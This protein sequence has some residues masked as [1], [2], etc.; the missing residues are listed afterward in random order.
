MIVGFG[1][2][3]GYTVQYVGN[4]CFHPSLFAPCVFPIYRYNLQ[5]AKQRTSNLLFTTPHV[6]I[7]AI[8]AVAPIAASAPAGLR[9]VS[10]SVLCRR[11]PR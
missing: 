8:V 2:G 7:R 3:G 10:S 6:E 4:D 1:G 9:V 5:Q 11:C